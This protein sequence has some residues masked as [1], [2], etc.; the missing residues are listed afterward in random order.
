MLTT[1]GGLNME[2]FQVLLLI[3]IALNDYGRAVITFQQKDENEVYTNTV[4]TIRNNA[5]GYE[6]IY[7]DKTADEKRQTL[8]LN[9]DFLRSYIL[10][11]LRIDAIE[12]ALKVDVQT[13]VWCEVVTIGSLEITLNRD[14]WRD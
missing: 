5:E 1:Y 13:R 12:G 10:E 6:V 7:Q 4:M 3:R 11:V 2:L 14:F 9:R 8:T